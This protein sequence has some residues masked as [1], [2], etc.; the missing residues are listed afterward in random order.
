MTKRKGKEDPLTEN[1]QSFLRSAKRRELLESAFEPTAFPRSD[2]RMFRSLELR[3]LLNAGEYDV[4]TV[5]PRT[6]ITGTRNRIKL[7]WFTE[8]GRQAALE[9]S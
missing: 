8:K 3:G 2:G 9:I 1:Q 6:P 7:Y 5:G 4:R